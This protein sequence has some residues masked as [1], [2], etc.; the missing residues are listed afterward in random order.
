MFFNV[1]VLYYSTL[2]AKSK[3]QKKWKYSKQNKN[4][5]RRFFFFISLNEIGADVKPNQIVYVYIRVTSEEVQV[6]SSRFSRSL[7]LSPD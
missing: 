3:S 6:A 7:G 1:I 5:K 2:K 4:P